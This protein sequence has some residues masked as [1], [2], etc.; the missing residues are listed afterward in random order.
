M[1]V[2]QWRSLLQQSRAYDLSHTLEMT[3]PVSPNH[4][5]FKMALMRRHGD[6]V[7]ADGG[8]A[9]N[10]MI[11]LGGHTGTHID[12]LCHVS[13]LGQ[14]H[15]GVAAQQAQ[16]SFGF[17]QLGL[18]T[19]AP[20][21]TRGVLIDVAGLRGVDCLPPGTA[22]TADDLRQA[23]QAQGVAEPGPGEAVVIRSGWSKHWRDP[24][25]YLG[26]ESGV[27][28]PDVSAGEWLAERRVRVAGH[29]SMAFEQL[30]PGAGHSVLPV[31][32]ILLVDAGIHILENLM[33][34]E[35]AADRVYE[36][37]FICA[38]LKILGATGC[39]VRPLAVVS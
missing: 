17:R 9:A 13:H 27:P 21:I 14:L 24:H 28:G 35:L 7:R 6:N 10:E 4:P 36:F 31:H 22:V 33:L 12:A 34:D 38:P 37:L 29:D 32:K 16:T 2:E 23:C 11:V 20:M 5:G 25:A 1:A 39:P 18:E 15:G 3:I 8:S 26:H 30:K 19:V